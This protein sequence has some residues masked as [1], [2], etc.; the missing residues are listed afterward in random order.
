MTSIQIHFLTA[1]PASCLVRGVDG[2][3]KTLMWTAPRVNCQL[4]HPQ[5][6]AVT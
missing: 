2:R 6:Y 5:R 3:P 4:K 1:Y